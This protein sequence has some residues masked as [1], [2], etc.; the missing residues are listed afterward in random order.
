MLG[1][2]RLILYFSFTLVCF[3]ISLLPLELVVYAYLQFIMSNKLEESLLQI[4]VAPVIIVT[5]YV[6]VIAIFVLLHSQVV[7]RLLPR[8]KKGKYRIETIEGKLYGVALTRDSVAKRLVELLDWIPFITQK[9]LK[10]FLFRF[11]GLKVGKNVYI[12][13]ESYLDCSLTS[14]GS[15]TFIGHRAL[16]SNHLNEN[17]YLIIGK[18]KIGANCVIGGLTLIS[19]GVEIGDNVLIG[20]K[21][22]VPKNK[23][24][25]SDTVWFGTPIREYK[26]SKKHINIKEEKD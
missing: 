17:G 22:F 23:K 12:A 1:Y 11:Y 18:I 10:P 15:N 8:V 14:I 13:T 24:L 26:Y 21:S 9:Y 19:P 25:P 5:T 2:S 16:L 4:F 20:A 6:L 7:C 3:L